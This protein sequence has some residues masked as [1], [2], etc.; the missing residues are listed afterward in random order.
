M[1]EVLVIHINIMQFS[2]IYISIYIIAHSQS[3]KFL[4]LH[5]KMEWTDLWQLL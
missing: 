3:A 1:L 5:L 4:K 2:I